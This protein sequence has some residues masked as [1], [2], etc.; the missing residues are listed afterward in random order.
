[1]YDI[2]DVGVLNGRTTVKLSSQ[3]RCLE[4]DAT[5]AQG[6][7]IVKI[8]RT[9]CQGMG[10]DST[11]APLVRDVTIVNTEAPVCHN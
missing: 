4:N 6:C 3:P 8:N 10:I 5:E 11:E 7:Y 1:M 2:P 9:W